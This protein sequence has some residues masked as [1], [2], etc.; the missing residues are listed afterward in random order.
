MDGR[1]ALAGR[2]QLRRAQ[3]QS[4]LALPP[5]R[6]VAMEA[7]AARQRSRLARSPGQRT[8]L[9]GPRNEEAPPNQAAC[10]PGKKEQP[11]MRPDTLEGA[12]A[13]MREAII[14]HHHFLIGKCC[15]WWLRSPPKALDCAGIE[16]SRSLRRRNSRKRKF[17]IAAP[18]ADRLRRILACIQRNR[19]AKG[20]DESGFA[21]V[22]S[23]G[24]GS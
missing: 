13:R 14:A 1:G 21:A 24:A 8:L 3:P 9:N 17:G 5:G 20:A 23:Y 19:S 10:F 11:G 15:L 6:V 12:K 4:C 7:R 18:L 16:Q 2:E 22:N